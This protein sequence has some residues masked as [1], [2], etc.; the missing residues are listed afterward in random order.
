MGSRTRVLTRLVAVTALAASLTVPA[1]AHAD[2]SPERAGTAVPGQDAGGSGGYAAADAGGRDVIATL[3]EWPWTS[4][5][6]ECTNVLGPDGYGAVQ[7]SPPQESVTVDGHPWWEV[8]Q[9][10]SYQLTSRMGTRDQFAAMVRSCHDAGV[11]VYAD[12]VLNHMTGQGNTGYGG[13]TF[14]DKYD[15]P[16]LYGSQDFHHYPGD[17]PES[18]GQ[19]HDYGNATEVRECELVSL[20]D[21]RTE[22]DYV[23][24]KLADYLNDL[25]GLGVD[26]FRLD[27]AKHV[28]PDDIKA[29][30]T[31]LSRWTYIYQEV[32][33][34]AGEAVQPSQYEGTGNLLEFRYGTSLKSAFDGR[35]ADLAGLG[36]SAD[37]KGMEPSNLAVSFVDN[38]DTQRNGSTLSYQDG[39]RYTL[40][41]VFLLGWDYGTPKVMSSF[42]FDSGDQS[43][44]AGPDG[45][46]STVDCDNGWVCEHRRPQVVGMVGFHNA[47]AG[48]PVTNW[49]DDGSSRIAFGRGGKGFVAI[50]NE[51]GTM[52]ETLQTGLPAGT[53]CDVVHGAASGGGCTGPTV[54]VGADG[55][56]Q[57]TVAPT[58]AVAIDVSAT[59]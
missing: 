9:P 29:I 5:A 40:A 26:G 39:A 11:R 17:C 25:L 19:I 59:G 15:Y 31:R 37:P 33:Y 4:V 43:P 51:T 13:S 58:D 52:T 16:G 55:T 7:V 1:A 22:S 46:V 27:A 41:D 44:P 18:D 10:V 53:Y 48:T 56:A 20:A 50:N 12:A 30:E 47:V 54:T 49:W 36:T 34:G 23:R 32:S 8:Y 6:D 42:A 14:P 28:S 24:G 38:W 35:L 3:F 21:L 45:M 2:T 57:V